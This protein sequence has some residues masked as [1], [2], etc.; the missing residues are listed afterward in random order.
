LKR[1]FGIDELLDE[2]T[3]ARIWKKANEQL[4]T[5]GT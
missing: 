3:A 5:P 4:A 2:S 1:Y